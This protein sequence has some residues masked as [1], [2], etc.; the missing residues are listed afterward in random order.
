[1]AAE[2]K[3]GERSAGQEELSE[4]ENEPRADGK[5]ADGRGDGGG[6]ER[7]APPNGSQ[8]RCA[9]STSNGATEHKGIFTPFRALGHV[10][11]E[12]PF[13]VQAMG[14]EHFLATSVGNAFHIYE[15]G[16]LGLVLVGPFSESPI[17]ALVTSGELTYFASGTEIVCCRRAKEVRRQ[18]NTGEGNIMRF[19]AGSVVFSL[20][21][22][23][24]HLITLTED[25]AMRLWHSANGELYA[26]VEFPDYFTANTIVHPSTYLNKVLVSSR[27]GGMQLWNIR[28]KGNGIRAALLDPCNS[29]VHVNR[30][31]KIVY[32]FS[33]FP[34]AV[35]SLVQSP[36][37]DV[38]A[39]GLLDGS[40]VLHNIKVDETIMTL[41][42]EGRVTAVSF[43][44]DDQHVMAT[45]NAQG[46]VALWDLEKRQLRHMIKGAHDALI[47]SLHFVQGQPLLITSGADNAVKEW[48]FDSQDGGARLLKMR[49][50]HHAPPTLVRFY[51]EDGTTILSAARDRSLRSFSVVRDQQ[52]FE[53]SQ[54]SLA[55][56]A[57]SYN[58]KVDEL[59]LPHITHFSANRLR[60][61]VL[62]IRCV[63]I[64]FSP[65]PAKQKDWD[66]IITVHAGAGVGRTWSLQRKTLG[67]HTLKMTDNTIP[68]TTAISACGNFAFM[69][70][71]NGLIDMFNIQSGLHR[72]TFGG[73]D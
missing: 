62:A 43:R 26:E 46:D 13:A 5:E 22:F 8:N 2:C 35:T 56:K 10:T 39:V 69:G 9:V 55:K 17:T 37:V 52:S 23:G 33:R 49:G 70:S 30:C 58:V 3:E 19:N 54:G 29:H 38:I 21:L 47:P 63:L 28:T 1:M 45:A 24:E 34:T 20:T 48:I 65:D 11:N 6:Q 36:V 18:P 67:K 12:V 73:T 15:T 71:V 14:S 44:T 72:R 27:E 42:Q 4:A 64:M 61:A 68:R 53:I 16:K 31:S 32:D 60:L 51:G 25:N 57:K 59:K 7:P 50:G 41:H 40:I 66:N